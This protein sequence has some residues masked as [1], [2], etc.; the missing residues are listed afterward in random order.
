MNTLV[1]DHWHPLRYYYILTNIPDGPVSYVIVS[2]KKLSRPK[3]Q[4]DLVT[5]GSEDLSDSGQ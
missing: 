2:A 4:G 5:C 3:R 1:L